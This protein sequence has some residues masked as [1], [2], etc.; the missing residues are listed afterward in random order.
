MNTH[1]Y[2][3][4]TIF[5][6]N[7]KKIPLEYNSVNLILMKKIQEKLKQL[8]DS[9]DSK[10][11]ESLPQNCNLIKQIWHLRFFTDEGQTIKSYLTGEQTRDE[12]ICVPCS[13][14]KL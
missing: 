10:E 5:I 12:K 7:L 11:A 9:A 3:L 13:Y 4:K 14:F 1:K 2:S 8:N 6:L